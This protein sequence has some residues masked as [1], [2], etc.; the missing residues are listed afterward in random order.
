VSLFFI[1]IRMCCGFY[2]G[3]LKTAVTYSPA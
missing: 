1:T 2:L 3:V